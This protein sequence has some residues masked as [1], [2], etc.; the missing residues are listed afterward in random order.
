MAGAGQPQP[1]KT[2]AIQMQRTDTPQLTT[3]APQ[4]ASPFG[5]MRKREPK[6]PVTIPGQ[7]QPADTLPPRRP[8]PA[9]PTARKPLSRD[10]VFNRGAYDEA[11]DAFQ[12]TDR[13]FGEDLPAGAA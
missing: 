13:A 9:K 1:A 3:P 11:Y 8:F 6:P 5:P 10:L 7:R 4:A 2:E 12:R